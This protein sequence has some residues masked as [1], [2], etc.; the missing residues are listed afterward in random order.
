MA[1]VDSIDGQMNY[2][3]AKLANEFEMARETVTKRLQD[4]HVAPSGER[5]GHP[6]YRLRAAVPALFF[7]STAVGESGG[8]VLRPTDALALERAAESRV[9]RALKERKLQELEGGLV[10]ADEVRLE[11]ANL[12]K[13]M[14]QLL[15][16]LPDVLERDCGL[17]PKM[18]VRM[19]ELISRER[20]TLAEK[21][22]SASG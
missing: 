12:I 17:S 7:V 13:P 9:D 6:T 21:L 11:M 22:T 5:G 15:D 3:I 20:E 18:V 2:S 14:L 1:A 8:P 10:A 19:Q 16:I 4:G